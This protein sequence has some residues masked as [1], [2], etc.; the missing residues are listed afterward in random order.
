M[1]SNKK[2]TKINGAQAIILMKPLNP[3]SRFYVAKKKRKPKGMHMKSGFSS[4]S[5]DENEDLRMPQRLNT[6][7]A[8]MFTFQNKTGS[9]DIGK[10]DSIMSSIKNCD[11]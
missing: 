6:E 5:N 10:K 4:D 8:L 3:D 11:S 1:L 2:K 7:S 9:C